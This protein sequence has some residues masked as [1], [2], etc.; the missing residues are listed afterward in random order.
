MNW[1]FDLILDFSKETHPYCVSLFYALMIN[2][3]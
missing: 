1:I 3:M 2:I